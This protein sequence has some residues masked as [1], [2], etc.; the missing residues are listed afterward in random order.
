MGRFLRL[1]VLVEVEIRIDV[2]PARRRIL[3]P[4]LLLLDDQALS[5]CH[6]KLAH[7]SR[8]GVLV[9]DKLREQSHKGDQGAQRNDETERVRQQAVGDDV[10]RVGFDLDVVV[11]VSHLVT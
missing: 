6:I 8:V 2:L 11:H 4:V 9:T 7:P 5:N 3:P 1:A 10:F